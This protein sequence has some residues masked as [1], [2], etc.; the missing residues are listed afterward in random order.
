VKNNSIILLA[1]MLTSLLGVSQNT[2]LKILDKEQ[3]PVLNAHVLV[4]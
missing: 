3:N 4:K 1:L 2:V